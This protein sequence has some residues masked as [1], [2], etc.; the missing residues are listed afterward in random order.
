[1]H[2]SVCDSLSGSALKPW[3]SASQKQQDHISQ[4]TF[5]TFFCLNYSESKKQISR[6][7]N[8]RG[9]VNPSDQ[10]MV[11]SMDSASIT[12]RDYNIITGF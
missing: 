8:V 7:L 11:F 3:A 4:G 9:F 1:M 6:Y 5:I 12:Q 10:G 2:L